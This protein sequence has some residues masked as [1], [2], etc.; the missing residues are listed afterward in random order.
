[1]DKIAILLVSIFFSAQ[2]FGQLEALE[3]I[4]TDIYLPFME[5]YAEK[6]ARKFAALQCDKLVR[7]PADGKKI[8][9]KAS[10]TKN[11]AQWWDNSK[12][13]LT[14]DFRFSERI[15][16]DNFASERGIYDLT[17]NQG[18]DGERHSYGK[19][20]V[21]LERQTDAWCFLI[22]YD[23]SESNTIGKEDF[24]DAFKMDDFKA[25]IIDH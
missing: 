17:F 4:N 20:H 11:V 2:S 19:F 14:I 8:Y 15:I 10:Y 22:D 12:D 6:D 1:M 23:S 9:D 18:S 7:V 21:I 16:S 13:E 25:F 24:D 5:S 3:E